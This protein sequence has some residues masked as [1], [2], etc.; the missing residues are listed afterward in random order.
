MDAHNN[1]NGRIIILVLITVFTLSAFWFV[2]LTSTGRELQ[3]VGGIKSDAQQF[4]DAEAAVNLAIENIHTSTSAIYN[5][6]TWY[7]SSVT[8]TP[9]DLS[10]RELAVVTVRPIQNLSVAAG[11]PLQSHEFTPPAGS[12]SGV[13]TTTGKRYGISAVAGGKVI[14]VGVYRIVPK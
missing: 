10:G 14:Q 1:E 11:F 4:F 9:T 12:G 8:M 5:S 6:T 3:W 2:A 7:N 13:N